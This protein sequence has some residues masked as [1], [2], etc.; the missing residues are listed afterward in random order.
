MNVCILGMWHLGSVTAACLAALGHRVVGLDADE[1]RIAYL[2]AGK[3]PV[4]EPGVEKWLQRGLCSGNV[5]F[6]TAVEDAASAVDVPW[7]ACD[8]ATERVLAPPWPMYREIGAKQPIQAAAQLAM[9]EAARFLPHLATTRG[10]LS[11]F[12]VGMPGKVP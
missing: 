10:R 3:A 9:L 8:I 6:A 5:R 11:Y 4:Y 12:A 7:V 1:Q 2:N